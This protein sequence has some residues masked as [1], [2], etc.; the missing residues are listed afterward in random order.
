MAIAIALTSSAAAQNTPAGLDPEHYE[1]YEPN[2][3]PTFAD[4][5]VLLRDQFRSIQLTATD[6]AFLCTPVSKNRQRLADTV[7]HLVCYDLST[8]N[9]VNADVTTVNQFGRLQFRVG[10]AKLLCLPTLKRVQR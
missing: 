10:I 9:P 6:V 4:Q 7:T 5:T 8:N 1:C 2:P 3:A